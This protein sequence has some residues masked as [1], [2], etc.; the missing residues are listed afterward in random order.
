MKQVLS[1]EEQSLLQ[2]LYD[3]ELSDHE[4]AQAEALLN[5]SPVARVFMAALE[6]LTVAVQVAEEE[7]WNQADTPSSA[8][9][10]QA[11][12]EAASLAQAPMTDLAPMLE[13]FHDG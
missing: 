9:L 11:A 3:R 10:V 12:F 8:P 4:V 2:R 7:A 13:R 6:E 5:D 1:I